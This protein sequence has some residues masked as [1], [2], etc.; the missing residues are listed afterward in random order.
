MCPPSFYGNTNLTATLC[1]LGPTPRVRPLRSKTGGRSSAEG[2]L[3]KLEALLT[4][5]SEN[6]AEDMAVFAALLS[7]PDRERYSLPSLTPQ[8]LKERTL[9]ALMAHLRRLSA[10]QPMLLVFED[11]HWADPTTVEVLG[12]V[13]EEAPEL[14]LLI[15]VTARPEFVQPWPNYRHV[16]TVT[17]SRLDRA[18]GLALVAAMTKGKALP[19]EVLNQIVAHTDGVP[20][21]IEE[22]TKTV[23]WISQSH[24]LCRLDSCVEASRDGPAAAPGCPQACADPGRPITNATGPCGRDL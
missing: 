4:Q 8:Q 2:K 7:I 1:R 3:A 6:L 19:R 20:L 18:E 24:R 22:L 11:L 5:S 17:M 13:I 9:D 23:H 15:L 10:R 21:F 16:S 12:R 14:P